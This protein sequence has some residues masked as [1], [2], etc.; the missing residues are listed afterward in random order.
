MVRQSDTEEVLYSLSKEE[1]I[2]IIVRVADQDET[3]KNGLLVKYS[4]DGHSRKVQ[5][6]KKLID[7]IVKKYV[8]RE[9]FIPYRETYGYATEMLG[10]L[11]NIN[12][13]EDALLAL[14]I[15]CLVLTEGV[16]AFQYA[17][18]SNG[19]IGMLVEETL[20]RIGEIAS[21]LKQDDISARERFFNRLLTMSKSGDFQGWEEFQV[22]L[23]QVCAKF[24]DV[25]HLRELLK[26]TIEIQISSNE[27]NDYLQ[28]TNELLLRILFQLIQGHGSE[29]EIEKFMLEH[30]HYTFFREW[31]IENSMKGQNYYR[32]IELAE[33]GEQKD[34]QL[35][36]L[37]SKWKAA[38]YEAYKKL[39]LKQE[40]GV[41]GKELLL[42]G[43]YAYYHDLESLYKGDK[44]D[45]YREVIA[46][47]KE[48]GNWRATGVYL[49]LISDRNDLDE[50]MAYVTAN[51]STIEEYAT[52]LNADY[53]EEVERIYSNYIYNVASTS[54]NRKDYQRVCAMLKRYKKIADKV[55][56]VEL[57]HQLSVQY[58]RRPAFL[59][60]LAKLN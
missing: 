9:G 56:Y 13:I 27:N 12:E 20:E 50:I 11:E 48:S 4:T 57:I 23:L 5:S 60:E 46:E 41:L 24:A 28:Y 38:R 26:A 31:A 10:V 21:N 32:A 14:E 1:L 42:S 8:G 15:A 44:K 45:F 58:N 35:P 49:K 52:R 19:D 59:D 37:I 3:F 34:K 2:R 30:L 36:G 47:L 39:S 16:E 18:D 55:N 51:P 29:E 6:C 7:S 43:E 22:S 17:D 25:E 53:H 54:S 40:Q 33:E